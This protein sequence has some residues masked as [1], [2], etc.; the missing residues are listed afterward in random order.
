V[1]S[2]SQDVLYRRLNSWFVDAFNDAE[3]VIQYRDKDEGIIKG[4]YR[5]DILRKGAWAK[6]PMEGTITVEVREGRYRAQFSVPQ[7]SN[8]EHESVR[9]IISEDLNYTYGEIKKSWAKVLSQLESAM[10]TVEEEW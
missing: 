7:L 9:Y 3:S 5:F 2:T 4:K 8:V 10:A 6:T 1:P